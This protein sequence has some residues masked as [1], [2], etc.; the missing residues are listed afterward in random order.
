MAALD[1]LLLADEDFVLASSVAIS[2]HGYEYAA[3]AMPPAWT[4]QLNS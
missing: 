3:L 2:T 1:D 4:R